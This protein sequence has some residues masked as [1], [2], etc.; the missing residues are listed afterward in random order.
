MKRSPNPSWRR[1][2]TGAHRAWGSRQ[3]RMAKAI[4]RTKE[5]K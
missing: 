5:A 2:P 1:K 4:G 3:R